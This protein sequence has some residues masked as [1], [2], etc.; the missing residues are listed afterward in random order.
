[1]L[2][3]GERSAALRI[4]DA[5]ANRAAEGLRVVEEYCRFGLNDRHLTE[6]CKGMR[7]TLLEELLQL[8]AAELNASR[9]S[10][11]DV[12][13]DIQLASEDH[14]DSL[15]SVAAASWQR[16]EQALRSIEEYGKLLSPSLARKAKLLR[17]E[18][19]VLAKACL[20]IADSQERLAKTRLYVLVDGGVTRTALQNRVSD[21]VAAGVHAIQLRDKKLPDR[22]L[23]VRAGIVREQTRGTPTLFIMND[24]PDL[25]MLAKADGVHIGQDELPVADVRRIVGPAMLVGVSTHDIDQARQAVVDGANYLGCGPTFP[26]GTK[27]FSQFPGL[28]FLRE[29]AA[30]IALPAFAI[31]GI[32][33]ENLPD[34]LATGFSRVAIGGALASQA[35]AR[36]TAADWLAK[37][38]SAEIVNAPGG[39]L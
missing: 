11:L 8:P 34:V 16:V 10:L 33:H 24:R 25:A 36:A 37:L 29:V 38:G 13:A 22:E 27:Q 17:Y 19:Y 6:R 2:S 32:T 35:D 15:A 1:M 31:G 28:D 7:H 21:L 20:T 5:N 26:S 23:L 30:E 9:F 14:R 4:V 3:P 18:G 39:K 12:G